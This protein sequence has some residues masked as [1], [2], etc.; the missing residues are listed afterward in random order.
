MAELANIKNIFFIGI[1]GIGMSG[2]ARYFNFMGKNV[3]GYDKTRTDLTSKL[4]GE[5]I[6]IHY[7]DSLSNIPPNI[8]IVIYTPAIPKD[9][10]QFNYFKNHNFPIY[11]RSQILGLLSQEHK[12]LA[13]S[14]THGKTTTSTLLTHIL[15][16][17]GVDCTAFLGGISE[18]L[19]SNFIFGRSPWMVVEADEYDRSFLTLHPEHSVI[20]SV[21]P[22]H[23][24]IYGNELEMQKTFI[25]FASQNNPVGS[26]FVREGLVI[27]PQLKS[28]LKNVKTYGIDRGEIF[29]SNIRLIDGSFYFDYNNNDLVFKDLRISLPGRHNIENAVGAISLSLLAGVTE[30]SIREALAN[31]KGIKR[32]FE[33]IIKDKIVYIDDYA[34]H[35]GELNA[36]I[37]AARELYPEAYI[38][39]I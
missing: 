7:E 8:D 30:Q 35:P 10:Q 13:V 34:H 29:A 11:K 32:R 22:D 9:H 16:T 18:N 19:Q 28:N 5:G 33:I 23:L 3:F 17:G 1:G 27:L 21:D 4:E 39:G 31:F 12:V 20:T 36:A 24:D 37:Q 14:G 15:V 2:L 26:I 6:N 38:V 25:Q